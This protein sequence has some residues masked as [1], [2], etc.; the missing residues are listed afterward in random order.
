MSGL[1]R[2]SALCGYPGHPDSAHGCHPWCETHGSLKLH[3]S[4]WECPGFDGEGCTQ[5]PEPTPDVFL[6]P[7]E[8]YEAWWKARAG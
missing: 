5:Y 6:T 4:W 2:L 8:Q 3:G 7:P 1:L